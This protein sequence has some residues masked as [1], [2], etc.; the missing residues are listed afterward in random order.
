MAED[1]LST[2]TSIPEPKHHHPNIT[3]LLETSVKNVKQKLSYWIDNF[4]NAV[5][6]ISNVRFAYLAIAAYLFVISMVYCVLCIRGKCSIY[7]AK[8]DD[9]QLEST[10]NQESPGFRYQ[11]LAL[12]FFFYFL[13][14]GMEVTYGGF[15]LAFAVEHLKWSKSQATIVTSVF[16]GSFA[17]G[18][19]IS[20]LLA[21]CCKP[22]VMLI[23]DLIM[24]ISSLTVLSL[25]SDTYDAVVW[26]GS[27]CLG[28]G[29]ASIFPTGISW[30]ERYMQVTGRA[31]AVFVVGCALGEMC[32]P[33]FT[34]FMFEHFN[35]MGL[36]YIEL[37]CA[38]ICMVLYIIMQNIASNY[39]VKYHALG[40]SSR[41]LLVHDEH[42][43]TETGQCLL[44]NEFT[45][46]GDPLENDD[47]DLKARRKRVKFDLSFQGRKRKYTRLPQS[48][49]GPS[50]LKN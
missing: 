16:W 31:T 35:P 7:R 14:V 6:S 46:N 48:N 49:G 8:I 30:A 26:F 4:S 32:L 25:W 23:I 11:M 12:L 41:S 33:A 44:L 18:R 10:H 24:T 9:A 27:A 22:H 1:I 13:Y 38:I 28:M 21:R 50:I 45:T 20:I 5:Y 39:G 15:L 29:M 19:G 3:G 2:T 17:F 42:L 40:A 36:I 37:G 47:D 43:D 34:G